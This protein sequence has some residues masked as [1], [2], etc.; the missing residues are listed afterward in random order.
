MTRQRSLRLAALGLVLIGAAATVA[1]A[2]RGRGYR[3]EFRP[4][5]PVDRGGVPEWKNDEQFKDD[6]FRK[7]R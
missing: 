3:R 2:Q 5:E 1:I 7:M 4:D 6:V